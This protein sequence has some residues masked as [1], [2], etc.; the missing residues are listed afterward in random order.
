M[1][2]NVIYHLFFVPPFND[3][4]EVLKQLKSI[5][6]RWSDR[7]KPIKTFE[8]LPDQVNLFAR[9]GFWPD[10]FRCRWMQRP[11]DH[12]EV[13]WDPNL[14]V[15][16]PQIEEN[17]MGGKRFVK[18]DEI[19][20][21]D[22]HSFGEGLEAVRR[23]KFTLE[24]FIPI[25]DPNLTNEI[26]VQASTLI[27]DK[28]TGQLIAN[29]R[30]CLQDN[31]AAIYSIGVLPAYKGRGLATQMLKRALSTL[32]DKYSVLRLY[33]MEGNDAESVY[34]NLGFIPGVQEIQHMYIPADL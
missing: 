23:K 4:F 31:Q 17:G 3:T 16:S 1:E 14:L 8:V 13:T 27:F 33:V 7:A 32:K 9:A 18:E 2:P 12:F 28:N 5:L 24:D 21:C 19:A 29:C 34:L 22:F 26:L 20:H 30:L 6:I 11:T 25:E 15:E 10:E